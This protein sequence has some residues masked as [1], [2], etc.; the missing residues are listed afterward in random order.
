MAEGAAGNRP[1]ESA[2]VLSPSSHNS[3]GRGDLGHISHRVGSFAGPNPSSNLLQKT[4]L[5]TSIHYDS[6]V[7]HPGE[8]LG[9][10]LKGRK[11]IS[12]YKTQFHKPIQ[13]FG[14]SL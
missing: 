3:E 8:R 2:S 9:L 11:C 12:V 13:G 4:S 7:T 6:G 14:I 1:G 10:V 5:K